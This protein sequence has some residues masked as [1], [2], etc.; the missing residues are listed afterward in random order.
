MSL[1]T[2]PCVAMALNC[3]LHTINAFNLFSFLF[4]FSCRRQRRCEC[5]SAAFANTDT[6]QQQLC[7]IGSNAKLP[8]SDIRPQKIQEFSGF[9]ASPSVAAAHRGRGSRG[10]GSHGAAGLQASASAA[11]KKE[12]IVFFF[13]LFSFILFFFVAA[14]SSQPWL[15]WF[16]VAPRSEGGSRIMSSYSLRGRGTLGWLQNRFDRPKASYAFCPIC[17]NKER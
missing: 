17:S 8:G 10:R 3:Q 2:A 7:Y 4:L 13:F 9:K 15:T 16:V 1:S 6:S 12:D 5:S 14:L 11:V